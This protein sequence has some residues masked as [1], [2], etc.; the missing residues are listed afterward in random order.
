M[1]IDVD[2]VPWKRELVTNPP[3]IEDGHILV[4]TAPGWG[5]DID[6]E[7]LR[8]HSWEPRPAHVGY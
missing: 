6:E 5:A 1:E 3:V 7:V 4:P 2:D 8:A